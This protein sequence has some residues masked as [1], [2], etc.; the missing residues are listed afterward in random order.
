V[1]KFLIIS[2]ILFLIL[3][4]AFIK[5]STKKIDDE[6]FVKQENL[7]SLNKEFE[8]SKLEFDYLS[9]AEKLLEFRDLYFEDELLQK[10]IQEIKIITK[11]KNQLN[12]KK[13]KFFENN[14]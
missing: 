1:K 13:L 14:E 7:R 2:L 8:V 6:I 11:K 3:F 9:S 12:I 4:T 10:D 5:N